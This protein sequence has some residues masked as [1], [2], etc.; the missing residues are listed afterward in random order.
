[1]RCESFF[2][3]PK[4]NLPKFGELEFPATMDITFHPR[5]LRV[6]KQLDDGRE[7]HLV[8]VGTVVKLLRD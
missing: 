8:I 3:S 2:T 5:I 7:Q 6:F 4:V 1:M